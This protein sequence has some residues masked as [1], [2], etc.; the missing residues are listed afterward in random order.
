MGKALT[1]Q[2][3]V[4]A[5]V[6]DYYRAVGRIR[7]ADNP[8]RRWLAPYFEQ[9]AYV[10]IILS[11]ITGMSQ[12]QLVFRLEHGIEINPAVICFCTSHP[13]AFDGRPYLQ[14]QDDRPFKNGKR[15]LVEERLE[16]LMDEHAD[17]D[18]AVWRAV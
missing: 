2:A 13:S 18:L 15:V 10:P 11:R 17:D 5:F 4:D 6:K 14:Y 8:D 3:L 9:L 16:A 7:R 1:G 12:G